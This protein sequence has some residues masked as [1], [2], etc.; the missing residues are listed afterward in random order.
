VQL[1]P[2][3][4]AVHEGA[5]MN[6]HEYPRNE[7]ELL[8]FAIRQRSKVIA[9]YS[10]DTLRDCVTLRHWAR[11]YAKGHGLTAPVSWEDYG[12]YYDLEDEDLAVFRAEG[13]L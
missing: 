2:Y 12:I 7:Q 11:G 8:L 5:A 4:R 13:L 10:T 6:L 9:E 3:W 1:V